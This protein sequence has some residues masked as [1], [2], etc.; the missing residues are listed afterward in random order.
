ME[1][2]LISD[3]ELY[4]LNYSPKHGVVLKFTTNNNDCNDNAKE[5]V[6]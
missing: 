2:I 6:I 3:N 5:I 4:K 1:S